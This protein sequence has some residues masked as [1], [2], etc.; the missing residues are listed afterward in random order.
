MTDQTVEIRNVRQTHISKRAAQF[1]SLNTSATTEAD[2]NQ[3][4]S[5]WQT[6]EK[7]IKLY[8]KEFKARAFSTYTQSMR[9]HSVLFKNRYHWDWGA[10]CE[11][12]M[13]DTL[14]LRRE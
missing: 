12:K 1:E 8:R 9:C 14:S 10:Q 5:Q 13:T 2:R 4:Y 3:V 6:V 7:L 11:H